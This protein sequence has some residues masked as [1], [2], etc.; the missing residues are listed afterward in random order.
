MEYGN[1]DVDSIIE[2]LLDVQHEKPGT[3]ADLT[4]DE[5][6]YLWEVSK[7]I[8]L[9]QPWLL[10]LNAPVKIAGDIHGQYFDLLRLFKLVGFPPKHNYLFLGDYVDRGRQS[11]ECICLL[12]AYKIKYPENFFLLRGNHEASDIN[13]IHGFYDEWRRRFN[14]K[15][16]K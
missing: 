15:T 4:E 11:I 12:L 13:R 16:W 5:I 10:E 3:H 7:D 9:E 6:S 1:V 8:F 14:V 2:K